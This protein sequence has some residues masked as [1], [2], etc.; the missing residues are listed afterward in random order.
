LGNII[1]KQVWSRISGDV[2][3]SSDAERRKQIASE[4]INAISAFRKEL[5]GKR[6]FRNIQKIIDELFLAGDSAHVA[7]K[8][9]AW[10]LEAYLLL[11]QS[12]SASAE[13]TKLSSLS[14]DRKLAI[15]LIRSLRKEGLTKEELSRLFAEDFSAHLVL[16]AH[17]TAGI[18][19]DYVKHISNMVHTAQK[20][21]EKFNQSSIAEFEDDLRTSI[22]HMVRAKPY[23]E[24]ALRPYDESLNFL[25][26]IEKAWDLIPRK[27]VAL[28]QEI[29]TLTQ[30]PT[31]E[32]N[33]GFFRIHSWVARDIDGNPT[34]T[35]QEHVESLLMERSLFLDKYKADMEKLIQL[36]SDDFTSDPNLPTK[37][38]FVDEE[39]K[40]LYEDVRA[41]HPGEPNL[42]QAYRVVIQH[43]VLD[44]LNQTQEELR[45]KSAKDLE[46]LGTFDVE[47]NLIYPLKLIRKNKQGMYTKEIDLM[48]KK[49]EIF[50]DTGSYGHT[51]Q[52][53]LILAD[54]MHF[55][56]GFQ[57]YGDIRS[58]TNFV[59]N[60]SAS[61]LDYQSIQ[62][63]IQASDRDQK[64]KQR[65]LQ[66]LDLLEVSKFGGIRR[67]IISM[68]QSF[69]DML[70]VLV[71]SKSI[72]A[73]TPASADAPSTSRLEI[74]PL[75]EQIT[76]LRDSY[77]VTVEALSNPAWQEYLVANGAKFIKMRGPSDSGKQNGFM[78]SQQEMFR[79]KRL[80]TMVVEI[81]NA[82]LQAYLFDNNK[83]LDAWNMLGRELKASEFNEKSIIQE[84]LQAFSS[85]QKNFNRKLWLDAYQK[86]GI[87][88]VRLI[89]FD[90]WGEPVERGGGLEFENTVKCTQ[91]LGSIAYYER[92]L[93][94]GGAQQLSSGVRTRQAMQ[95]F[96]RGLSEIG[97]RRIALDKAINSAENTEEIAEIFKDT[98]CLSRDFL[99]TINK[100]TGT[101]RSRLRNEVLGI[102]AD[103]D[104]VVHD[105]SV[106]RKYFRHVI[107]SPLIY[108]D[109]FNIAS[110]PTSRSGAKLRE[111]LDDDAFHNDI[112]SLIDKL[113]A[114]EIIKILNDIRAIPYAAMFSLL[115]GN[116]V[117]FY[118]FE[119]LL[120]D[121]KLIKQISSFYH[122]KKDTQEARLTR[123]I[124]DSLERGIMTTDFDCYAQ[125]YT[126]IETATNPSYKSE[127]DLW[128]INVRK[129][130]QASMNFIAEVKRYRKKRKIKIEQLLQNN[131]FERDLLSAR[132]NDAAIPRMGIAIAMREILIH[133][134]SKDLNPL[135]VEN[136]PNYLLDLLRKAFAAGASTFGNGC[137]D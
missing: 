66:S 118:G 86:F 59:L 44:I 24:R 83:F 101:L 48:L 135:A 28:E 21:A 121:K 70:N 62:T 30:N 10:I 37:T 82:H 94:G 134:K 53:N 126:I 4:T 32:L 116:H 114:E 12:S 106:L 95:D 81:F 133:C 77:K 74:V 29:K 87:D 73:F 98:F 57:S 109:L 6:N 14:S 65:L 43:A 11:N 125:A 93:Q 120:G 124:I 55:C 47:R 67:Q 49:A 46:N 117:S 61:P 25:R 84:A 33:D 45:Y 56:S 76:D 92:T 97:V 9:F 36:L 85:F 2:N 71:L 40:A 104:N 108:L 1:G 34:V 113:E 38:F 103:E 13:T 91:P 119:I 111:L 3:L 15:D 58:K 51:R 130:H 102:D 99:Q 137:I 60:S 69:E 128:L 50:G 107:K 122:Q 22:S 7:V 79:S 23:N 27:L 64:H 100:V 16:T 78:V 112:D 39:F 54:L 42:H 110:R 41:R 35:K 88:R 20:I 90:G 105:E 80:D 96:I 115:G 5:R 89:S 68:N 8:Q 72:G 52:G 31:F 129:A 75:T 136:I 127:N 17:P 63:K 131:K 18:Q 26:N 123:H 19:P 132:R